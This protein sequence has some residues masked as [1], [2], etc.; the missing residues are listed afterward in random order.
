MLKKVKQLMSKTI[1]MIQGKEEKLDESQML[2]EWQKKFYIAYGQHDYDVF[3]ELENVYRGTKETLRNVNSTSKKAIKKTNNVPNIIYELIE[4]EVN[5]TTPEAVVKSKKPG[6]DDHAKM[7]QEKIMSDLDEFDIES[8]SDINERNTYIHGI[9]ASL[10]SWNNSLGQH[11]FLGEKEIVNYHPKQVIP[12]PNIYDINKMRYIFLI[13]PTT[14]DEVLERTGVSVASETQQRPEANQI[15]STDLN[16]ISANR[17][18]TTTDII[19]EIVC[20]Y[21]DKDGDICKFAWVGSTITENKPKYYYPRVA[22]CK[23]CGAENAQDTEECTECG[24]KKLKTKV[25]ME[26][27]I[28]QDMQLS[29]IVYPKKK[30]ELKQGAD[31]EKYVGETVEQEVIERIVPAGTRIPI[32]APKALPIIIRKNIPLNFSFRGRSDVETIRDQQESL[33]KVWSRMEEKVLQ[34]GGIVGIPEKLNKQPSDDVYQVWKGKPQDLAQIIVKDYKMTI[35]EDLAFATSNRDMAKAVLGITDS[36]QGKY[37]PSAKSGTAKQIQVERSASR[38]QSKLKNKFTFYA[39]M[40]KLMFYFDICFTRETRPYMRKNANGEVEYQE[41][42]KYE[43]LFQDASGEWFFNTD[44]V[45]K[46]ELGSNLP[47]DKTFLYDK[48]LEMYNTKMIDARQAMEILGSLD[49]PIANRILEQIKDQ[50]SEQN[51]TTELLNVLKSMRP[52]QITWFMQMPVEQQLQIL[53]QSKAGDPNEQPMP[54]M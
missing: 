44:F 22:E 18:T 16:T 33:K 1:L 27:V 24:S 50:D 8:M 9:S 29:P 2:S 17:N 37:D 10:I 15:T 36:Y 25:V 47:H 26:E 40:F 46:A 31:G 30:K 12:Q 54:G 49:F 42:N 43:L 48:T 34:G 20:F 3:D 53:E 45:F 39:D 4:T 7:I 51:D 13:C 11:E 41:F 52:E 21:I 23:E 35:S 28:E 5:T 14:K 38:L 6:F 19:E 32:P